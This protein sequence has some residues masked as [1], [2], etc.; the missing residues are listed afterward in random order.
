MIKCISVV[1][2]FAAIS[3]SAGVPKQVFQHLEDT[4][5]KGTECKLD[6]NLK[7]DSAKISCTEFKSKLKSSKTEMEE[8][9][10]GSLTDIEKFQFK[11][12]QDWF[13]E[14]DEQIKEAQ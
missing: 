2:M 3:A 9:L 8:Y 11:Y 7:D 5:I 13:K 10:K 14:L 12:Y 4:A 6:L 1:L